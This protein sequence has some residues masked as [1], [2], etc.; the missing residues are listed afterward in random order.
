MTARASALLVAASLVAWH[1]FVLSTPHEH[2]DAGVPQEELACSASHPLSQ[3]SHL[4]SSGPSLSSH[5]CVACLAGTTLAVAQGLPEIVGSGAGES[6]A[7]I[8]S[9][10]LRSRLH[11]RLP[12]SR[13]PPLS[14]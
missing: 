6:T 14:A 8:A 13:G 5:P 9:R 12:L 11:I 2:A 3:S 10:D 4:H 7:V 1:G